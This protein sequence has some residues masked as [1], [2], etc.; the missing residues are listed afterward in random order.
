MN[1]STDTM[2]SHN[3]VIFIS[4]KMSSACPDVAKETYH[5]LHKIENELNSSR[6]SKHNILKINV[7]VPDMTCWQAMQKGYEQFF[8]S[9][10]PNY[11]IIPTTKDPQSVAFEVIAEKIDYYA[12]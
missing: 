8:G 12:S 9:C 4:Q 5:S 7:Y 11:T 1:K 2:H 10:A 3:N 6:S